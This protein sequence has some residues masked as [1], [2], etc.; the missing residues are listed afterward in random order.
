MTCYE[1]TCAARV[2]EEVTQ[3]SVV[4]NSRYRK[5]AGIWK[6]YTQFIQYFADVYRIIYKLPLDVF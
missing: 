6:L 1:H 5:A 3:T 4:L 2:T